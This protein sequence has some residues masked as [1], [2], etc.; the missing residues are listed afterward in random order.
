[1][2]DSALSYD[3]SHKLISLVPNQKLKIIT[4]FPFFNNYLSREKIKK[5]LL[6]NLDQLKQK[7]FYAILI[8]D[9]NLLKTERGKILYDTLLELKKCKM[10][11]KVG[12]SI[13]DS[14]E[15]KTHY[16]RFKPEIV[17]LPIN[18]FNQEFIKN[19]WLKKM[20]KDKVEIHA[21]SIFLQGVILNSNKKIFKKEKKLQKHL[22][23]F[24]EWLK[25]NKLKA[26]D[27][28]LNFIDQVKYLDKVL[29]GI[30]NSSQFKKV[31][32]HKVKKNKFNYEILNSKNKKLINPIKW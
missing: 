28:A 5:I 10:V 4:K 6:N 21:R 17:Q 30:S 27:A 13:Y 16:K 32:S 8:H 7:K 12:F 1:M 9:T 14:N 20:K 15:L 31:L 11:K 19:G 24:N 29:V 3:K 26:L 22:S 25:Q 2:L 23:L 18:L